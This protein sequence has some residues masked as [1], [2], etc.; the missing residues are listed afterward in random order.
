MYY[1]LALIAAMLSLAVVA[2]GSD[3]Q[4]VS[5]S[6]MWALILSL[7][8]VVTVMAKA[9]KDRQEKS[10][11]QRVEAYCRATDPSSIALMLAQHREK[12]E[13]RLSDQSDRL[14]DALMASVEMQRATNAQLHELTGIAQRMETARVEAER[15]QEDRERHI[16]KRLEGVQAALASAPTCA[17][18]GNFVARSGQ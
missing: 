2:Q 9:L 11:L 3:S 13:E 7:V 15:R 17:A 16:L 8:A 14:A 5:T 4:S 1:R 6:D 18:C 10:G 12:L